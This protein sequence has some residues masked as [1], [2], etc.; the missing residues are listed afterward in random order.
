MG[1]VPAHGKGLGWMAFQGPCQPK[2]FYENA[3]RG[4][5]SPARSART[6]L[7]S[8]ERRLWLAVLEVLSS[9]SSLCSGEVAQPGWD[10]GHVAPVRLGLQLSSAGSCTVKGGEFHSGGKEAACSAAI[11]RLGLC[12]ENGLDASGFQVSHDLLEVSLLWERKL[13][14]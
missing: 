1:G 10:P 12:S 14:L 6:S 4:I 9:Q 2:P 7:P 11:V 5:P 3:S 8:R 13:G